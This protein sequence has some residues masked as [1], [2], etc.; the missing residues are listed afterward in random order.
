VKGAVALDGLDQQ[1][2]DWLLE[3]V[4]THQVVWF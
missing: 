4:A 1:G 3:K 2:P